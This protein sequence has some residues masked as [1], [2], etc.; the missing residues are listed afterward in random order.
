MQTIFQVGSR[1]LRRFQQVGAVNAVSMASLASMHIDAMQCAQPPPDHCDRLPAL[2]TKMMSV[3]LTL[4]TFTSFFGD[5]FQRLCPVLCRFIRDGTDK[6][7][8]LVGAHGLGDRLYIAISSRPLIIDLHQYDSEMQAFQNELRLL[9]GRCCSCLV[10]L[11]APKGLEGQRLL[12]AVICSIRDTLCVVES[13]S[14][15]SMV[16]HDFGGCIGASFCAW[17]LRIVPY[18]CDRVCQFGVMMH[19]TCSLA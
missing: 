11:S 6:I 15:L 2:Y 18:S 9:P 3:F 19:A 14:S 10:N 7:C 8:Q 5:E 17:S 12:E 16:Q 4:L 1:F 13:D